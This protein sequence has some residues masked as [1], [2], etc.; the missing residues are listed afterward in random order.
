MNDLIQELIALLL[1]AGI[2]A[3]VDVDDDDEHI[4]LKF[5]DHKNEPTV[6]NIRKTWE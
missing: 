6:I 3:L 2:N 5:D 1:K 4:S